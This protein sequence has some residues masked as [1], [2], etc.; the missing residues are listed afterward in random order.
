MHLSL[1]FYRD[2]V[3][4]FSTR[5]KLVCLYPIKFEFSRYVH[6]LAI[7][8]SRDM[9]VCRRGIKPPLPQIYYACAA[10]PEK[11][12][13]PPADVNLIFES[14]VFDVCLTSVPP[15]IRPSVPRAFSSR[16]WFYFR[17]SDP[18]PFL[19]LINHRN[20]DSRGH[21]AYQ[22]LRQP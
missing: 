2:W 19:R 11:T 22:P 20:T 21:I 5:R 4:F 1:S 9:H 12:H 6:S 17:P 3:Y 14:R 10:H 8:N 13:P 7:G 16:P 18:L 15:C